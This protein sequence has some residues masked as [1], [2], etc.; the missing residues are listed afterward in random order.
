VL[1]WVNA[2]PTLLLVDVDVVVVSYNSRAQLRGTVAPLAG[3]D[4]I[5]VIVVDSASADGSLDVV[6]GLAEERIALPENRGFA[7]ACNRGW[8]A[9][10]SGRVLF[11][12]PDAR[13]E[14][15]DLERLA[16]VLESRPE[17][18]CVGPRIVGPDGELEY[19][20]RRFPRLRSRYAQALFLQRVF[21]D[22]AWADE[23]LRSEEL[24]A[25]AGTAE[26][27][28][29]ACLLLR[30]ETLEA[31]DGLDDG[32]FLYCEDI[33]LCRR[34]WSLGL[35]VWYEP[36]A[37]CVHEGGASAPRPALLPV[38]AESRLRYA[39]KHFG[40]AERLAERVGIGLGSLTHLVVGRRGTRRG[41]ARA[42]EVAVGR[43]P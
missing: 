16:A 37:T 15:A 9:G 43:K 19:S 18:G 7:Y 24:Y 42:L 31:L 17:V 27:L 28:S 41:H 8:R 30:R 29:G 25:R 32:F 34:V 21:P 20:I 22:A 33:D 4:G 1:K 6:E 35:Q 12:N 36:A 2:A 14:P 13:I 40:P 5:H 39:H 23:V 38:L 10:T 11:L 26:W 3:R